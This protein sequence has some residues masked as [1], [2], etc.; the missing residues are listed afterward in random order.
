M[1][2]GQKKTRD[3]QN[4]TKISTKSAAKLISR[5]YL[6]WYGSGCDLCWGRCTETLSMNF[7]EQAKAF[8]I[9]LSKL[10]SPLESSREVMSLGLRPINEECQHLQ[11]SQCT[12][13]KIRQEFKKVMACTSPQTDETRITANEQQR[14]TLQ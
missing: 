14:E 4:I 12:V 8:E 13:P 1:H 3:E 6:S 11:Y 10:Q 9:V 2:T 5:S 7:V